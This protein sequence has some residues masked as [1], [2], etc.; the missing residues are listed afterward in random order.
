MIA[1]YGSLFT[2]IGG[3]DRA[4]EM[5]FPGIECVWQCERDDWRRVVLERHWGAC[6]YDDVRRMEQH[7]ET[8]CMD[9]D[10]DCGA[11]VQP[12]DLICGGFPCQDVAT[13]GKRAGIE[14]ERSG[15]WSEFARLVGIL[16]PRL[17]FVE[18]VAGLTARGLGRVLGDLA[19]LGFDAEWSCL[20]ARDAGA[21]HGRRR[22]FILA[23]ADKIGP[24][25][26]VDPRNSIAPRD[27][28][29]RGGVPG[30]GTAD[31]SAEW[32][33]IVGW[34]PA[35]SGVGRVAHGLPAGLARDHLKAWGDS[36]CP[37]QAALALR[38]LIHRIW[39]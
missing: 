18:N 17:V 20:R 37:Q 27:G 32:S 6:Q 8:C 29:V 2:G 7:D 33:S 38:G 1:S 19:G 13:N 22:I 14:G 36:V 9:E 16:R 15:L 24:G 3:L 4:V 34:D 12:V 35:Q 30:R 11:G 10:C 39:T 5:V 23:Y 21:L 31:R 25:R 26:P 28:V